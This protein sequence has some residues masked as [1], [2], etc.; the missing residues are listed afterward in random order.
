MREL[1]TLGIV[2]LSLAAAIG[3]VN[4]SSA[5]GRS[6]QTKTE[7]DKPDFSGSWVRDNAKSSGLEGALASAE[8][9]M[10]ILHHDPEFKIT[11]SV[12]VND[13]QMAQELTYYTDRRGETNPATFGSGNLKSKTKWDR[14]KIESH[15]SWSRTILSG[16]VSNFDSTER[17]EL[18]PDGKTLKDTI[19]ISSGQ[20][21][22]TLK[23]V[24]DRVS[25]LSGGV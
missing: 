19:E 21:V 25:S 24:F 13:Q 23:Q 7:A 18:T 9:T 2:V 3:Q 10:M 4:I 12:K 1:K 22:K 6:D 8:L 14:N 15:A 20:G 16:E 17:W 11:R 5:Q